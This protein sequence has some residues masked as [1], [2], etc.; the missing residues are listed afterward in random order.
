MA[1]YPLRDTYT[2]EAAG[3]I[4]RRIANGETLRKIC[5]PKRRPGIPERVTVYNW[6]NRHPQFMKA[7]VIARRAQ[8]ELY[9]DEVVEIANGPPEATRDVPRDRL[10]VDTRFKL[11]AALGVLMAPPTPQAEDWAP[12]PE[13]DEAARDARIAAIMEAARRRAEASSFAEASEDGQEQEIEGET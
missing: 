10:K 13:M 3:E 7:Y 4:C 12:A 1:R 5:G 11:A 8:M 9:L 6:L 2:P